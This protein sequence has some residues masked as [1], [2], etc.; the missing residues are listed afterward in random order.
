MKEISVDELKAKLEGS[1]PITLLDIREANEYQDWHICGSENLPVYDA[2]NS[3]RLAEFTEKVKGLP[4]E[5]PIVVVCRAGVTS[6]VACALL[7]KMGFDAYSLRAGMHG[8]SSA[9]S[10]ARLPLEMENG[11]FIQI[12]RNGKGCL[13][14]LFGLNGVCAVV[15]PSVD[16]N[17]YL[18]IAKG[19]GFAIRHI[20]ET[21]VHADHIS[22]ARELSSL[23]GA[24]IYLFS[25][26]RINFEYMPLED[27]STFQIGSISVKVIHSP[28][29]TGESV[30]YL[31]DGKALITGDTLF[32]ESVGRPDL[33]KGD[34]GAESG[35]NFLYHSLHEKIL[36]L[37]SD[38]LILPAHFSKPIAFDG[39]PLF[40][41]L[42]EVRERLDLLK[43]NKKEFIE[44][45]VG[46]LTAKPP[47]FQLVIAV[48]EGKFDAQGLD[49][50]DLEAG[51]NRCAV[52]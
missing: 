50:L 9:W 35:A 33:E 51:P 40:T 36:C 1:Q 47:N 16:A 43:L 10:I 26:Q 22:R 45:I 11:S 12:R 13:S 38:I 39:Q 23:T 30:C 32:I 19:E 7:D 48:N 52:G 8:F 5:K 2:I 21:H 34:E 24:P 46:G 4:K 20:L 37:D 31:V 14:Y 17:V 18:E 25:N 6:K 41:T 27:G 29:H 42:C 3:G 44:K 15:D 28:G 49:P